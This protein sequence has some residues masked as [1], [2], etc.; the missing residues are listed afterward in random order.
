MATESIS[1]RRA[2]RSDLPFLTKFAR[3]LADMHVAIDAQRFTAP[4]ASAFYQF[5][6]S[7][8]ERP[9]VLILIADIGAMPV[10][11]AFV[12]IEPG[13]LVLELRETGAYLHDIFVTPEARTRGLGRMLLEAAFAAARELGSASL[14]L[15]VSPQNAAARALF[16]RAGF[17]PTMVEMRVEL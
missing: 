14:M 6:E 10:G 9:D 17:R 1:V 16:E 3:A 8:L 4:D 13:N 15:G 5:F 11:Y 2:R 7:E 12:R